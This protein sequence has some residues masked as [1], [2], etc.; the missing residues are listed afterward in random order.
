MSYAS[1]LCFHLYYKI[2]FLPPTAFSRGSL[3]CNYKP[4]LMAASGGARAARAGCPWSFS[5]RLGL[6][7]ALGGGCRVRSKQDPRRGLER[8]SALGSA[9]LAALGILRPS[10]GRAQAGCWGKAAPEPA[11][12]PAAG[13]P[14]DTQRRWFWIGHLPTRRPQGT[15]QWGPATRT[16]AEEPPANPLSQAQRSTEVTKSRGGVP[17]AP[18]AGKYKD[19]I[20]R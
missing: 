5:T 18:N 10:R 14:P 4:R 9:L 15:A 7:R 13:R 8:A 17:Y 3:C 11:R 16:G 12:P 1:R 6:C 19:S 20:C 2:I